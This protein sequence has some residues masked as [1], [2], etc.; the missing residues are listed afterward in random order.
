MVDISYSKNH[1]YVEAPKLHIYK[2]PYN[3]P[4][5]EKRYLF[6]FIVFE[7]LH[8]LS[9]HR[10]TLSQSPNAVCY[11]FHQGI[12]IASLTLNTQNTENSFRGAETDITYTY[13][14]EHTQRERERE[15]GTENR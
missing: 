15:R 9:I 14:E 1:I 2:E 4:L 13:R 8:I 11:L 3:G 5:K 6:Y 10:F 12:N 7:S